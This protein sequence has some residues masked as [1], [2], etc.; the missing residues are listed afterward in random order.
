VDP[1]AELGYLVPVFRIAL[2]LAV[3]SSVAL[4]EDA[5]RLDVAVGETVERDVG[6]A[7]GMMCDDTTLI[8]A[9]LRNTSPETNTFGVTG[10]KE[11]AAA[12]RV[13]TSPG[14]PTFLFEIHVVPVRR[15]R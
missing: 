1:G 13:G 8:H 3:L 14:R 6:Y 11:G 10:I 12:C 15:D 2:V 9:E 7:L 4:A 5:L